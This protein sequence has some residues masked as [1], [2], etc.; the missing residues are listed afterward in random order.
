MKNNPRVIAFATQKGG[1]GKS[2]IGTHVA[3]ALCYL[4]GYKVAMLDC[5]YPQNTLHAYRSHEQ[6]LLQSD[7]AFQERLIKQGITP[8]PIAISSMEK[9][10]DAIDTLAQSDYDF[11][12]V[13]TPGTVNV[14]GLSELLERVDYIFLPMEPDMGTIAS[15]MSYMHILGNFTQA[16]RPESN[17]VGFY[18]FWNK[19]IKAEKRTAYIKTE[20]LFREKG[21]P[22]LN[23][24]VESLVSIK[25]K[26]STMF[27]MSEKE[28]GKLGLGSLITEMLALVVGAGSKTPSGK[29]IKFTPVEYEQT[30]P[31]AATTELDETTK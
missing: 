5:D 23:S 11:I 17:L 7:V 20:A 15:T 3:S 16:Q 10:V 4:Y 28:L 30:T 1:A 8:Y 9:A 31:A 13:D 2:T 21:Y 26:R 19:F 6:G 27:P 29:R 18:A 25:E 14:T 12:L 24:R 22:L